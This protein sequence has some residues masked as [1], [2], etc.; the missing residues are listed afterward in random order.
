MSGVSKVIFGGKTLVDLTGDTVVPG[1]LRAGYKAHNKSGDEITGTIPDVSLG[2]ITISVGASGLI[3]ASVDQSPGYT[4]GGSGSKTHQ[5]TTQ[6]AQT[7]TPGTADKTIQSGRYL[8]G[9]QTIKGDANL[10]AA[11]IKKGVTIFGVA[12]AMEPGATV[13]S[14]TGVPAAS[15]GS[16]GDIYVKTK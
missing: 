8:T 4:P 14:G 2:T 16:N 9:V 3:T 15:L 7:I 10:L 6:A 12:G 13:H 5:L 11:N 1:A